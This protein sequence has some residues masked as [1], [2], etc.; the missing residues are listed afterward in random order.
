MHELAVSVS[1]QYFIKYKDE[2]NKILI[3]LE[4]TKLAIFVLNGR[5]EY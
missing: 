2:E 5:R 3:L 4:L 1:Y